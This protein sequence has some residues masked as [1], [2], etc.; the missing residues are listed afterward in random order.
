MV[1]GRNCFSSLTQLAA[2]QKAWLRV[3][4]AHLTGAV[5]REGLFY[6]FLEESLPVTTSLELW[7]RTMISSNFY[8]TR[9]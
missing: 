1:R 3:G 8:F 6:H 5:V 9:K 2:H 7:L 4:T